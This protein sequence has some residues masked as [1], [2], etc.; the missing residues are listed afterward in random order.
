MLSAY[1]LCIYLAGKM[2]LTSRPLQQYLTLPIVTVMDL[3]IQR[4]DWYDRAADISTSLND[5]AW[6]IDTYHTMAEL[7]GRWNYQQNGAYEPF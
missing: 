3:M 4:G 7:Y 6:P 2:L 5:K 1:C